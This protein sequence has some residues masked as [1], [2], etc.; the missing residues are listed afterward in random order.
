M[1]VESDTPW[2]LA[3]IAFPPT[4]DVLPFGRGRSYGD[5]CLA[6][7]GVALA[8]ERLDRLLAFDRE[9]G[10]VTCESG[11]SLADLLDVMVPAGWTLPVLPG[12]QFVSVGGAIANDVHGKNH[13]HAGTFDG[14]WR[15]STCC[16][17]TGPFFPA[18]RIDTPSCMPR[19]SADSASRA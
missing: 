17:Q 11:V 3:D 6:A 18:R 13:E 7:D 14:T 12:T 10:F 1:S 16:A 2:S 9:S 19:R 4:G 5:C 15:A 8:T